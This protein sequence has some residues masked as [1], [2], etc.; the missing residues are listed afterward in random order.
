MK[1]AIA[2]AL[3][4]SLGVSS[5]GVRTVNAQVKTS[6]TF[7]RNNF[8]S[9]ESYPELDQVNFDKFSNII[10]QNCANHA[11]KKNWFSKMFN[12]F[13]PDRETLVC[14]FT[15]EELTNMQ[16]NHNIFNIP[17][18]VIKM[19]EAIKQANQKANYAMSA[20]S[21]WKS[22]L[23]NLVNG[24]MVGFMLLSLMMNYLL[25]AKTK[26]VGKINQWTVKKRESAMEAFN[27]AQTLFSSVKGQADAVTQMTNFAVATV[28]SRLAHENSK[29]SKKTKGPGCNVVCLVGGS[30]NGKSFSAAKLATII[31]GDGSNNMTIHGPTMMSD[32]NAPAF[33]W[34]V[35]RGAQGADM[36]SMSP[37][38]QKIIGE[39]YCTTIIEEIDKMSEQ[40][41]KGL[42][43]KLRSFIDNGGF[44]LP[45][46]GWIDMT[47][48]TFILTSNESKQSYT[49]GNNEELSFVDDGTGS[50]TFIEHDKSYTN[51]LQFIEFQNLSPQ[52]YQDI[53]IPELVQLIQRFHSEYRVNLNCNKVVADLAQKVDSLNQGA[54]P[55]ARYMEKLRAKLI[56][57]IVIPMQPEEVANVHVLFD[58]E[59]DEFV[60]IKV[61][62]D[63][64]FNLSLNTSEEIN[65]ISKLFSVDLPQTNQ[66]NK[67]SQLNI[68]NDTAKEEIV[69]NN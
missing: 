63:G 37:L 15:Q 53:L 18:T 27:V 7:N 39:Q 65:F 2:S 46:F 22:M 14:Q 23:S 32:P 20:P 30:G 56:S 47:G 43:E 29:Q 16:A 9:L 67:P 45:G 58:K 11:S 8:I 1:K 66:E 3:I 25:T 17:Y 5:S 44:H 6:A 69:S 41:R 4:L 28:E 68:G 54:R 50:R 33:G 10:E 55:I 64:S 51:R 35:Q 40:D 12:F 42:E 24:P 59:R 26:V 36:R 38:L 19:E 21:F 60:L 52:A 62:A 48:V 49:K 57:D 13:H 31:Q 61:N 34:H